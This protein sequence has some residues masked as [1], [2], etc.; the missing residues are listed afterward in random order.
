MILLDT[1]VLIWMSSD[2]KK[3]TKRAHEAIRGSA[4]N[5]PGKFGCRSGCDYLWELAWLAH[6][7][8]LQVA[9]SVDSYVRETVSRVIVRP[10]TAEICGTCGSNAR[11]FSER[12]GRSD[13]RR[14]RG[15]GRIGTP[16]GG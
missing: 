13:D 12:S 10:L 15:S 3:L 14:D 8:R 5:G 11:G 4:G 7:G 2:P 9:G 16:D 6:S 1:H